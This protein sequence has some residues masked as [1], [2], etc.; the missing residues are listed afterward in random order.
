[1]GFQCVIIEGNLGKAPEMR[2][3]ANGNAVTTFSVAVNGFN[4]EVEWFNVVAWEKRAEW[5]AQWLEK[6]KPVLV[7]GRLKT[8]SYDDRDG[9][10]RYR[11]ELIAESLDFVAGGKQEAKND[12]IDP[13]DL[14]F[15]N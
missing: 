9:I 11:V 3:T 10:K 6:G 2:Y 15:E 4:D 8:R 7:R 1:M 5:A 13:D 14:P 12:D